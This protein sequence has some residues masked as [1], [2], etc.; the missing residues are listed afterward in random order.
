MNQFDRRSFLFASS[1]AAAGVML[2]N[3]NAESDEPANGTA[4]KS[5]LATGQPKQLESP[6]MNT[7]K[8]F[9]VSGAGATSTSLQLA[10]FSHSPLSQFL[11]NGKSLGLQA[12][13]KL[14]TAANETRAAGARSAR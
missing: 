7:S 6:S 1:G 2:V 9:L 12:G 10:Q 5:G 13:M 4:T 11:S 3:G 14:S 8:G